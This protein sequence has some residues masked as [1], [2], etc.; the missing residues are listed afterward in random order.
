MSKSTYKEWTSAYQTAR[1]DLRKAQRRVQQFKTSSDLVRDA[2]VDVL[3]DLRS[4]LVE[5]Y[6]KSKEVSNGTMR[7]LVKSIEILDAFRKEVN[8]KEPEV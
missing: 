2:R 8:V 4:R 1:D 5:E 3:D 6:Q 7:G